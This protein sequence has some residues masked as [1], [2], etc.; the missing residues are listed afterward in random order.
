M[1]PLTALALTAL[2]TILK[3]YYSAV[4]AHLVQVLPL[5]DYGIG[6]WVTEPAHPM[7]FEQAE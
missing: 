2:L 1:K 5:E 3:R 7:V 4:P 6:D